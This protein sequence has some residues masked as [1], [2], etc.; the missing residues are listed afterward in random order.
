MVTM[1][2][3][4]LEFSDALISLCEL[5]YDA[6]EAYKVAI[7]RI[8]DLEYKAA[9]F[10]FMRDHEEHVLKINEIL[11]DHNENTVE[12]ASM[13]QILTKGKVFI[14]SVVGD[15]EILRAMLSNEKDTN[16]AYE[17]INEC[18]NKWPDSELILKKGLNDERRHK[19]W[20]EETLNKLK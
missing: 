15:K 9:L 1:V 19:A 6:I 11:V 4:Q 14:A 7:E 13:K 10:E 2:G 12:G 8:S 16:T 20:I 17:R 5:D 3:K 18:K